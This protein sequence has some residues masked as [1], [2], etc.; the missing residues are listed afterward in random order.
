MLLLPAGVEAQYEAI[1]LTTDYHSFSTNQKVSRS[2][3]DHS[4]L[5]LSRS[6][7]TVG[8]IKPDTALHLT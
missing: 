2:A 7:D 5:R 3:S 6:E 4:L 1:G 8:I